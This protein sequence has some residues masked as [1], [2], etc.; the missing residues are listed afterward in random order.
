[1]AG[2]PAVAAL[3]EWSGDIGI[4]ERHHSHHDTYVVSGAF[5]RAL[6]F[7]MIFMG[8]MGLVFC[9]LCRLGVF[10]ASPVVVGAFFVAFIVVMFVMW[11]FMRRYKVVTYDEHMDVTP[12]IGRTVSI[13]YKDI[14]SMEW[15]SPWTVSETPSIY[16]LVGGHY[17]TMLWSALDLEQ[18]LQRINRY[19]VLESVR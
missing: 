19:D 17:A 13:R 16:V 4:S 10:A 18:I 9:W 14:S 5:T 1:M 15:A 12:F 2:A 7:A 6:V 3:I 11:F 8:C